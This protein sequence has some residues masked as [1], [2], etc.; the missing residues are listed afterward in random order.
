MSNTIDSKCIKVILIKDNEVIKLRF[1]LDNQIDLNL[2]NENVNEIKSVFL[3]FARELKNHSLNLE[4]EIDNSIDK[5][6]DELFVETANE[7]IKQLNIELLSLE[8]DEDLKK[9]RSLVNTN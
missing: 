4:F 8:K 3:C 6:N 2:Q 7:Y 5:R 1:G 9:V